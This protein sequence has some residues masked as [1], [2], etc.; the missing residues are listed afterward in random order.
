MA[1]KRERIFEQTLNHLGIHYK[2]ARLYSPWQNRKVERSHHE[3]QELFY[4]KRSFKSVE[5]M[6]KK[7]KRYMSS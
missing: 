4:S 7:H 5:D 3:D 6:H 2:N 1:I